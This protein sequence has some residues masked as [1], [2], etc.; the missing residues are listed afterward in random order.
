MLLVLTSLLVVALVAVGAFLLLGGNDDTSTQAGTVGTSEKSRTTGSRE[1]R[2]TES[3]T[4]ESR[5]S[6]TTTDSR[7]STTS[8]DAEST[9]AE[10]GRTT[11][12]SD[13]P[14]VTT[15]GD[16]LPL[17]GRAEVG[18]Y[19]MA[20]TRVDLNAD[21]EVDASS[22]G[23]TPDAGRYVLVMVEVTN[24]DARAHEPYT[25]L[26]VVIS[27]T[28]GSFVDDSSCTVAA[29]DDMFDVGEINGGESAQGAYCLD[30]DPAL[31]QGGTLSV[32][33]S[34]SLEGSSWT[35]QG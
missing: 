6:P 23:A 22:G 29:P 31:L 32:V 24:I 3:R 8:P 30:L 14:P 5:A 11:T 4:T 34:D 7:G 33:D 25:D 2:T 16:T 1:S 10:P 28:D 12:E 20:V 15:G 18:N 9:T 35:L 27:G 13:G 26:T 19:E 17:G 21:A